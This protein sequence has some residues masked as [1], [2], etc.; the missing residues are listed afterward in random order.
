ML[1]MRHELFRHIEI[2]VFVRR[3]Q[4]GETLVFTQQ[5]L[6]HANGE[7][8]AIPA[9]MGE[10]LASLGLWNAV[11]ALAGRY[12][13][14]CPICIRKVLADDTLISMASSDGEPYYAISVVSYARPNDRDGYFQLAKVLTDCTAALFAGRPHWGKYCPL[15]AAQAAAAYPHLPEFRR[16]AHDFDPKGTFRNRWV[17]ET[18]FADE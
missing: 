12:T 14:H 10:R 2:E 13:H 8:D 3:A 7:R 5:L 15:D 9:S 1:T 18:L 16:I 17:M 4:L 11:A 6:C